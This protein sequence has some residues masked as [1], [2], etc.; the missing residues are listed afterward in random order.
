MYAG[1]YVGVYE[2]SHL[3]SLII[4]TMYECGYVSICMYVCTVTL[5]FIDDSDYVCM[6]VY[7]YV[8]MNSL[9]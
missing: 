3:G 2:Q 7:M 4:L 5:E 6:Q 9:T 1:M 8:C